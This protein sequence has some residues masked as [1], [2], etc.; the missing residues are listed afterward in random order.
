[1]TNHRLP[2]QPS[3][4]V[5]NGNRREWGSCRT[6]RQQ[7][8]KKQKTNHRLKGGKQH[9]IKRDQEGEDFREKEA[10]IIESTREGNLS[11]ESM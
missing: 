7:N 10:T 3:R 1:M 11:I 5:E 2:Y 6:G 8:K 9:K 4:N